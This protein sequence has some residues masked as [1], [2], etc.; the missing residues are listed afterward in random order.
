MNKVRIGIVGFGGIARN[1]H[2]PELLRCADAEIVAV[3]DISEG[4]LERAKET[5]GLVDEK[6]YRD[7]RTLIADPEVDAVE[8]C[9]PNHL[10]AEIAIAALNAGKP[11]NLEKPVAIN[12]AQALKIAE[13]E[14]A[15]GTFGMTCFTYRFFPAVRYAKHLVEKGTIGDIIGLDVAY[16]KDSAFWEGRRLEWRFVKQY[17]GSGV[18]G[19]LGIHLID[20]ARLL[21]G[22]IVKICADS[23]I[24]VKERVTLDGSAAGSVETEDSCSFLARFSS[25]AKGSFHIT[26]CAIGHKNTISYDVYGTRGAISF[27]LNDPSVLNVCAGE[28]DPRTYESVT[29]KVPE[30]FYITQEEAFVRAVK[31]RKMRNVPDHRGGR[32]RT[33][34]S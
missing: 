18:V 3:C 13:A 28:G 31:G 10:H 23:E 24:T 9:T 19:D 17:A 27:D 15:S 25:G 14:R 30:S 22:D 29:E 5:L 16:L 4:A 12:Y 7:Y 20:L 26:R 34:D 33:E 21:A 2:V 6:C 1:R 11:I 8:I 32:Q